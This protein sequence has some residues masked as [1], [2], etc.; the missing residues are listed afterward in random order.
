MPTRIVTISHATGAGGDTV[1]RMV[2]T[3]LGFRYIDEEII[4]AA[5]AKEELDPNLVA[6]A[7]RRKGFLARII[8]DFSRVQFAAAD[9]VGVFW[10]PGAVGRQARDEMSELIVE[11]IHETAK[12]GDVVIVAHAASI[13]LADRDDVLRVF[14][15]ASVET[16][17]Q[18][19]AEGTRGHAAEASKIVERSDEGRAAYFQ[20]F[21]G[22]DRELATHYDLV[23]NTDVFNL[24][25]AVDIV[26]S[27]V[28]RRSH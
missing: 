27:A 26:V 7:E 1:G 21:Y 28:R 23:L 9:G 22:I 8:A 4:S 16:R 15:T 3:R 18:R 19:V 12:Q 13:P 5:A 25:D 20:R 2:A 11:A 10:D 17:V 6:D 14:I 24:E